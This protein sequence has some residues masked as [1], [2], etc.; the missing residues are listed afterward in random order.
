MVVL[1]RFQL[2]MSNKGCGALHVCK[3]VR[4]GVV[5]NMAESKV[6]TPDISM[7]STRLTGETVR[8]E[9]SLSGSVGP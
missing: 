6:I 2:S 9:S 5:L 1:A 8:H 3:C 7:N 4:N